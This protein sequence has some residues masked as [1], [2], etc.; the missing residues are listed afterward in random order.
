M[1][2]VLHVT[3]RKAGSSWIRRI[4]RRLSPDRFVMPSD[5][6]H[7]DAGSD[8]FPGPVPE[9]CVYSCYATRE[10]V[11][12]AELPPHR[13]FIVVRDLRDTLCSGYFS[14]RDTHRPD[15][16]LAPVRNRLLE[17]DKEDGM[18]YL[19]DEFLPECVAVHESWRGETVIRYEDLLGN[20]LE[21]LKRVLLEECR[22]EVS[23]G[24]LEQVVR[25]HRFRRLTGRRRGVEAPEHL[26][27]GIEGDWRNHFTARVG[28]EFDERFGSVAYR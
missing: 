23:E 7:G 24:R 15:P 4:L 12:A 1:E 28:A 18:I 21:I 19:M 14:F 26:R 6:R 2:T 10:Q 11:E 22:L 3:H 9:G 16:L 25:S 27:K 20:D 5:L 13:R 17:L 8:P